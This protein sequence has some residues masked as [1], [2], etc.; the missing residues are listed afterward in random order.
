MIYKR[1]KN[2]QDICDFLG[3]GNNVAMTRRGE[4]DRQGQDFQKCSHHLRERGVSRRKKEEWEREREVQSVTYA[5]RLPPS[6]FTLTS[7]REAHYTFSYYDIHLPPG[8]IASILSTKFYQQIFIH[9]QSDSRL[10]SRYKSC[11]NFL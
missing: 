2:R 5:A 6:F 1:R 3:R 11:N 7:T 4:C 8:R 9:L 10:H